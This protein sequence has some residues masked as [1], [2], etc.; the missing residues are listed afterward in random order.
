MEF[1]IGNIKEPVSGSGG[2]WDGIVGVRGN[3]E[4]SKKWYFSYYLDVGTGDTKLSWEALAGLGYRAKK[5][6]AVFGYRYL[7][8]DFDRSDPGGELLDD[9]NVHGPFAGVKFRF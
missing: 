7:D 1:D 9:L 3:A 5:L 6:D 4:L 2:L 8:W